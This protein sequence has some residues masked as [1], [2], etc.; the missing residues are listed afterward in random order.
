MTAAL[1]ELDPRDFLDGH[2]LTYPLITR[3][4]GAPLAPLP[5][6]R[7]AFLFDVLPTVAPGDLER[8]ARLDGAARRIWRRARECGA[9]IYP[10]GFPLGTDLMTH[11][12]WRWHFGNGVGTVCRRQARARSRRRAH[13]IAP[14]LRLRRTK[15]RDVN[16][17]IQ[18]AA[19]PPRPAPATLASL[20]AERL[21]RLCDAVGMRGR[22]AAIVDLFHRLIAP[23]G[24][25]A[26]RTPAALAVSGRRRSHPLRILGR[27]RQDPGAPDHGRTDWRDSL[28]AIQPRRGHRA[29][30]VAGAD[31]RHRHRPVPAGP[32]PV[33][34]RRSARRLRHLD[35]G[36]IPSR[37]A[38][39]VQNLPEPREPGPGAGAGGHRGGPGPAWISRRPG[40]ASRRS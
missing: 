9:H 25:A 22:A 26:S 13:P 5:A 17:S 20:G 16:E 6:G 35:R 1:A 31:L 30:G 14:D 2:L 28:A 29:D 39:R 10:I 33:R 19:S 23:W 8:L 3:N 40:A 15:E 11:D 7:G 21:A 4:C 27:V 24:A 12:S 34:S 38:S 36:G 32:G 18:G 37:Q